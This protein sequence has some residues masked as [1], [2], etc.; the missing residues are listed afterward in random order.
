MQHQESAPA[1]AGYAA[2]AGR[3][4]GLLCWEGN[5]LTPGHDR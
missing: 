3:L 1:I 5:H 2:V 4:P